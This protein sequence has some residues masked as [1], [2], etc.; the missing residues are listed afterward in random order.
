MNEHR[1]SRQWW[2]TRAAC[3][4]AV[5]AGTIGAAAVAAAHVEHA[6]GQEAALRREQPEIRFYRTPGGRLTSVYGP[7]FSSG[8][9]P[10][11]SAANFADR[12]AALFGAEGVDLVPG[13]T[14]TDA[15]L[16]QPVLFDREVN[17]YRFNLVYYSQ[18]RDSFPVFRADLRLLTRNEP[19]NPLVLAKSALRELGDFRVAA[20]WQKKAMTL[21]QAQALVTK[22]YPDLVNFASPRT[23]IWAGYDDLIAEPRLAYEL[24]ADN[25]GMKAPTPAAQLFLVDVF[26]GAILYSESLI[27]HVDV[28]GTVRAMVTDNMVADVCAAEVSLPMAYARV[29]IG[30]TTAFADANGSFTIPNA[31]S[32]AVT[33]VSPMSGRYFVV[34]DDGQSTETLSQSVTPPGP[35][36]FLHNAANSG[37]FLRSEVNTYYHANLVR[38]YALRFNPSYPTV[39]T[40][41][42]FPVRNNIADTCNAFYSSAEQS[43][44]FFRAGGSC[45][46]TGFGTV[47]HHEYG[48]HLVQMA[49]SGQGG[50]GE[51]M[52]DV[53]SILV[54]DSSL[55]AVGFQNCSSALRNADNACL[56]LASG[57]S[58]CGNEVHA[59]GQLLS[60][61]VWDVRNNL[62]ASNPSTYR[63]ILSGLAV[64]AMLL[65]Q[66]TV[67][68]DS[69]TVDYL[70]LDDDDADI[71]NGTP[72]YGPI[73]A[74]FGEHNM[75]G[76]VLPAIGFVFPTGRP[77]IVRPS[78][79]TTMT[80]QVVPVTG[81][82]MPNSGSLFYSTG[83]AYTEVSMSQTSANVYTA[84]FPSF[85]CG[86]VV[87]YYVGART[88]GSQLVT[89]PLNAPAA[90]YN[91]TSAS[92]VTVAVDDHFE[93]ASGWTAGI[94]GDTATSGQWTRV[95]PIGTAAQPEDDHTD[96]PGTQCF[97]TGQGTAGGAIGAADIDNGTTTLVSPTFD[98]SST[99]SPRVSYWRWYSN[100]QGAA[101][102]SDVF[103][104]QIS[105]NNG[106]TWVAAET[107]GPSGPGTSG[108]WIFHEVDVESLL[109]PSAQ[110][111]VRFIASDLGSGSLVEAA[112]DDFRAFG[113][114]CAPS[115]P[116]DYN[117]DGNVTSQDFFD[118]LTGFFANNADFN[119]DGTTNSQ[120][121][122]D[123]LNAFFVPC[124]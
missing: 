77:E 37:E 4:L 94:A 100:D 96:A 34:T 121:F 35:V 11:E 119:H 107:V 46:N 54:T 28:S 124:P 23:V 97:V 113:F 91:T 59:C 17:A 69:I 103:T 41:V 10:A 64:N 81:Q 45:N 93:I 67:I 106:G 98:L 14:M 92:A 76:P 12:H 90:T 42:D 118:F 19:G 31:G 8:R 38:D 48:H 101:P 111:R 84:T 116:G 109:T 110:M 62:A 15:G 18:F 5:L 55:L 61:C 105:N 79:G 75:G 78:G 21:Q 120:D 56:Y 51:G 114:E 50:Y 95:D 26:T 3:I 58:T 16:S 40:Q 83:G 13:S 39:A 66:G 73:N 6:T 99:T 88:T 123:F 85:D 24:V 104:V 74:G 22:R 102:N 108:G 27:S 89:S 43:I 30:G 1:N 2:K 25:Q 47:V 82:P 33:V 72:H 49:G 60:G 65:H 112:V 117:N 70:T 36:S 87:S 20:D 63:E 71:F 52:G 80:V 68:N 115:C 7:A 122:F 29:S 32:G 86:T 44:N 57:C 9:T 53:M